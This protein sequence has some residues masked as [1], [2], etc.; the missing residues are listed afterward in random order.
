MGFGL[1]V[2]R[3]GHRQFGGGG[4]TDLGLYIAVFGILVALAI[5]RYSRSKACDALDDYSA[6]LEATQRAYAREFGGFADQEGKLSDL[7]QS[8]EA[9]PSADIVVSMELAKKTAFRA[10]LTRRGCPDTLVVDVQAG[11]EEGIDP[12]SSIP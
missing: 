10:T 1:Y 2:N 6:W 4:N 11:V 3:H 5:P 8:G 9:P 7:S 12:N